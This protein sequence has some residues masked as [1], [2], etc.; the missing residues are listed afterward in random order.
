VSADAWLVVGLGNPGPRYALTPHNVGHLV[1]DELCDRMDGTLRTHRSRSADV[2]E[3]RFELGGPRVVLG[4]PRSYMNES[5][6]PVKALMTFYKVP[7]ARL[8]VIHDEIDLP[9][10]SLRV[11]YGGGDNGHNGLRS[12]RAVLGTGDYFRVRVG[13]DRP[14][15]RR[16]ASDHLLSEF[17][18]GRRE[19][20][21]AVCA[22]SADA[23]I[24]LVDQGLERTQ[25]LFNS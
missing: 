7:T 3:G 10:G 15:G 8:V 9:F 4:R 22:R 5:G 23:V 24:S 12:L 13:V 25:G 14:P 2:L 11:K 6:G 16:S 21:P 17:P 18:S 1:L 19:E 20:L